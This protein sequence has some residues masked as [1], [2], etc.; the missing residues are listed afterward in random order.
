[1]GYVIEATGLTKRY[2][3]VVALNNTDFYMRSKLAALLGP[4]GA[5]KTTLIEGMLGLRRLDEGRVVILGEEVRGELPPRLARRVGVVLEGTS[6]L[7]NLTVRENLELVASLSGVK[8]GPRQILGALEAVGIKE[9]AN[10]RYGKLSTGQRKRADIASALLLE[11][12]LLILD[13][14]ESGLDPAARVELIRLFEELVR[15]RGI[16][17]LFSTHD[18][19]L[20]SRAWEVSVIVRGRVVA[21]GTPYELVSKFGGVWKARVTTADGVEKTLEFS[22]LKTLL[23]TLAGEGNVASVEIKP[24]DLF[25]AFRKLAGYA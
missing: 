16:A 9:L 20:A 1:M 15:E 23:A 21:S 8:I 4:N 18:I 22:D 10:R 6:L 24:P 13:E 17:V 14:P 3:N 11:P 5:G 19:S 25:E 2:G 12:E 7:E